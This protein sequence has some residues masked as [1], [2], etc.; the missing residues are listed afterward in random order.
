MKFEKGMWKEL[1][2]G[3]ERLQVR[4]PPSWPRSCWA[5]FSLLQL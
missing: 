3:A 4:T 5:N 1:L 2:Q